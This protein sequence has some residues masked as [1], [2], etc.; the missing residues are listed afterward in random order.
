MLSV[1]SHAHGALPS[2]AHGA[3]PIRVQI[4]WP[5]TDGFVPPFS[6]QNSAWTSTGWS[7]R[8]KTPGPP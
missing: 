6:A 8:E 2:H 7:I 1:P 4:A 5:P 3:L